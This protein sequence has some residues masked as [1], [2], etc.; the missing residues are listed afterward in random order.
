[1]SDSPQAEVLEQGVPG[2]ILTRL[3][4]AQEPYTGKKFFRF[5]LSEPGHVP[6]TN[7]KNVLSTMLIPPIT[8][9]YILQDNENVDY[10]Y[11]RTVVLLNAGLGITNNDFIIKYN[12]SLYVTNNYQIN[13]YVIFN[14]D[15]KASA[16]NCL[17]YP[18]EI[19]FGQKS[20][21]IDQTPPAL[22]INSIGAINVFLVDTD[23]KTSRGTMTTVQKQ[24]SKAQP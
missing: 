16:N 2:N 9:A 10:L 4:E 1:M 19:Y 15:D 7:F 18:I 3:Q 8:D 17:Y 5:T 14:Q 24:H 6:R 21:F 22:D 23:P 20:I 11:I 12:L 13:I